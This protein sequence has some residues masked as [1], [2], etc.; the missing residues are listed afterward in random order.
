MVGDAV[1][2]FDQL[3]PNYEAWYRTPLGSLTG[4]LE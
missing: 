1:D 4:E 3:A 2:V